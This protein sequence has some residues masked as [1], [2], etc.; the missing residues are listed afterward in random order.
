M[1]TVVLILN[2]AVLDLRSRDFAFVEDLA[3]PGGLA[4]C[5]T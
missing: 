4:K 1:A 5:E 3:G 2:T